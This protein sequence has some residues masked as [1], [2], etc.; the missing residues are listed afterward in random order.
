MLKK[1]NRNNFKEGI[2]MNIKVV[3]GGVLEKDGK[4]YQSKKFKRTVK[5]DGIFW[6][7]GQM[8]M[9]S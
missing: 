2:K 8:K 3:A 7:E 1:T 5:E 4:F 6:L 9:N